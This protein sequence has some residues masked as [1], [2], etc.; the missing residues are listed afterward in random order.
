MVGKVAGYAME[1]AREAA[2]AMK[3]AKARGDKESEAYHM[4]Q[5]DAY[6]D[7]NAQLKDQNTR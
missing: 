7:I 6:H 1:R 4:G 5:M 3:A 2:E